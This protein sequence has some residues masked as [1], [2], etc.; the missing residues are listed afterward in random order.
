MVEGALFLCDLKGCFSDIAYFWLVQGKKIIFIVYFI[1]W[2]VVEYVIFSL[3][4]DLVNQERNIFV[5]KNCSCT[6]F[7]FQSYLFYF[8]LLLNI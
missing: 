7:Y 4:A 6:L 5:K 2:T 1:V 3:V 8:I